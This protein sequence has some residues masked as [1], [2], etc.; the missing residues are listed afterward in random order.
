MPPK[1]MLWGTF[2]SFLDVD[3]NEFGLTTQE[4]A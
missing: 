2:A 4:I 1:Q 3:G